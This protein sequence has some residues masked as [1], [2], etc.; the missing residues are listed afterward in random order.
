MSC[1]GGPPLNTD[2]SGIGVR[3]SFYLQTVCLTCLSLRSDSPEEITGALYTLLATN[4]AMAVA[5][6]IL[7]LK[8]T[9]EISFHDALVITYLLFLSWVSV[10]FSMTACP[11]ST[12]RS[13]RRRVRITILGSLSHVQ[14]YTIFAFVLAVLATAR[15]F[16]NAR[17]CNANAV[18]TLWVAIV[19][20][21]TGISIR[22]YL[23][24]IQPV[25]EWIKKHN[26]VL[27]RQFLHR[28]KSLRRFSQDRRSLP[29]PH[30]PDP[31][32]YDLPIPW[33]LVLKLFLVV[34]VW[35]VAVMHV[36]LLIRWNHFAPVID[37]SQ[38]QFGQILPMFLVIIPFLSLL[39]AFGSKSHNP[40]KGSESHS[41]LVSAHR[42]R[43]SSSEPEDEDLAQAIAVLLVD[44]ANLGTMGT[45]R[46]ACPSHTVYAA[47]L[48][49][50]DILVAIVFFENLPH[51]SRRATTTM[52]SQPVAF[53]AAR[54]GRCHAWRVGFAGL[55]R[56]CHYPKAAPP[57]DDACGRPYATPHP[58]PVSG[59]LG[60]DHTHHAPPPHYPL[61]C[62]PRIARELLAS[63]LHAVVV[64]SPYDD[65]MTLFRR[66]SFRSSGP[67]AAPH[68][69][70]Y[71]LVVVDIPH[72][73]P[74]LDEWDLGFGEDGE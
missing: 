25:R 9:P 31:S 73:L 71:K 24:P 39:D 69:L 27:R 58:L 4:T 68:L 62:P 26:L 22:D 42:R 21:Y 37:P 6:L 11:A 18:V 46:S 72:S 51:S 7:G 40:S 36:E 45:I 60:A 41:P 1:I 50:A 30:S 49:L 5:A 70:S 38:W 44:C 17:E 35:S 12:E 2:V 63:S 43:A 61:L 65:R 29:R 53:S 13:G 23:P 16:G 20:L 74:F 52:I 59:E 10:C 8:P 48:G 67:Y 54:R 15:T 33:E 32:E 55:P 14:S 66:R 57:D 28:R 3:I 64:S 47:S 19:A 34:V 56:S